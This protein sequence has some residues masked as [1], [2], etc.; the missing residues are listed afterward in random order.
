MHVLWVMSGKG[1]GWRVWGE[2]GEMEG[3][4]TWIVVTYCTCIHS[5]SKRQKIYT[6]VVEKCQGKQV[7]SLKSLLILHVHARTHT[8]TNTHTH[9]HTHT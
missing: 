4:R 6:K 3:T 8:H 9:T 7:L 5:V 2:E 1:E